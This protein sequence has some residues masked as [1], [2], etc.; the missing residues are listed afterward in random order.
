MTTETDIKRFPTIQAIMGDWYY[1]ITTLPFYEVARRIRPAT[2][3]VAPR[4]MN[5]WIQREV[6]TRRQRQIANYLINQKERFFPGIVVG[7]YLGEPK[8]YEIDVDENSIFGTPG[9]DPRFKHSLGILEL[10]AGEKLYAIDGQHR[11]AGIREALKLLKANKNEE[12]YQRL[13]HETLSMVFVAADIDQEGHLERVRRLFTALNKQAKRVSE[14]E[15]VALDED[16]PAAIV[17]RWLAT[18]Y[19]GLN[20]EAPATNGGPGMGLIQMGTRN[21]IQPKNRHSVTTIV[22]LFTMTKRVFQG[23]LA[24]LNRK[25]RGS[26]PEEEEL[27]QLFEEAVRMWELLKKHVPPLADVLGTDPQEERAGKYRSEK[28][29]HILFR[30][31]GQ[32]AFAGALGVLRSRQVEMEQAIAHLCDLPMDLAEIPWRLVLWDPNTNSMVNRNKTLAE[33][34]FLYMLDAEPRTTGY[35]VIGTYRALHGEPEDDPV[36]LIPIKP[37][38]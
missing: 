31:V 23:E 11:V 32:Q 12:A 35:D 17:T 13:A 15:I 19:E 1:Y 2:E 25:H 37:I 4:N 5:F 29:G 8:W 36:G 3:L 22:T 18:D 10:D 20:R 38:R 16:D 30:P 26:R 24:R 6:I 9:L 7:V 21:E 28:G 33:A 34:L 27:R 14:A